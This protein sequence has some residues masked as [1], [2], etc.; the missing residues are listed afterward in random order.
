MFS[1]KSSPAA[2]SGTSVSTILNC[3]SVGNPCGRSSRCTSLLR[4]LAPPRAHFYAQACFRVKT[5][6]FPR[7]STMRRSEELRD[8]AS[9]R[10]V[11]GRGR[12][13]AQRM[14]EIL[15]QAREL[16]GHHGEIY[17]ELL[18]RVDIIPGRGILAHLE[19][20]QPFDL[21]LIGEH[22]RHPIVPRQPKAGCVFPRRE[23]RMNLLAVEGMTRVA[24]D[25]LGLVGRLQLQI[26][27]DRKAR[28]RFT[29]QQP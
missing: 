4:I 14:P 21:Q 29:A 5:Y 23:M 8:F 6:L 7:R 24:D 1:T 17:V 2:G 22:E 3:A 10:P 12:L 19:K 16:A 27:V 15:E 13:F 26:V 9:S 20:L 11:G 18:R 28:R 25:C